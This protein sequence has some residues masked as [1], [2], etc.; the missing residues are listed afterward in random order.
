MNRS[1][2]FLVG[3]FVAICVAWLAPEAGYASGPFSLVAFTRVGV[4]A[5]FFLYGAA[6]SFDDIRSGVCHWRLHLIVQT[7]TFV[8]FPLLVLGEMTLLQPVLD[9]AS[10][11][12]TGLFFWA[13]LPTTVSSSVVFV[14][15]ARGNVAAA[16]VSTTSSS[17]IGIVLTPLWLSIFLSVSG[18]SLAIADKVAQ[19]SFLILVPTIVGFC[20]SPLLGRF[21]TAHRSTLRIFDQTVVLLIVYCAFSETFAGRV[22]DT[23]PLTSLGVVVLVA[24]LTFVVI[25]AGIG[26]VCRFAGISV[27]DTLT[28]QICGSQ[29]SLMHGSVMGHILFAASPLAPMIGLIML[30]TMLYHAIQ[31][32]AAGVIV[33]RKN[34]VAK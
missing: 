15:L 4:A 33:G 10:P 22:F 28:S 34:S 7:T 25:F 1:H 29:K 18:E 9:V 20:F 32:I 23:T 27:T 24:V 13:T 16:V 21:V 8:A 5:I 19:T 11:L 3:L 26:V 2:L 6:L 12:R 14:A 31:L 17:L 30:P